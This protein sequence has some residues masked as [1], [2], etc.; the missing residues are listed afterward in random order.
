MKNIL[1]PTDFSDC[2]DNAVKLAIELAATAKAEVSFLHIMAVPT[3]WITL[4]D[5]RRPAY[6]EV[7]KMVKTANHNL[8]QL[9]AQAEHSG[10]KAQRYLCY[11]KNYKAIIDHQAQHHNDLIVMGSH[12]ATGFKEFF[13]GS[14]TQKVVRLSP[15]PVLTVKHPV[16]L[17]EIKDIVF[18]SDFEEAV[19]EPFKIMVDFCRIAGAKLHLLFIN[20]PTN[21]TDSLTTKTKM[22]NYA[23]HAPGMVEATHVFNYN[24]FE[25]GLNKF[26]YEMQMD[27]IS[28]ITHGTGF[29]S[30]S[31]TERVVN[32]NDLPV[33]SLHMPN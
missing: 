5:S 14:S 33:L 19:M 29:L 18:A 17:S 25:R 32:H 23:M 2:A 22:G 26:C 21:F 15:I 13:I 3:D 31:L 16:A 20:T 28:M 27:M 4:D 8:D 11:N 12:G 30:G 7:T 10:V 6:P 24:Q 9:V 1:I